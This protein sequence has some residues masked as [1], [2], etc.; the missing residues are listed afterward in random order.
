M[1]DSIL[2]K[3]D[4]LGEQHPEKLLYSYID[5]NGNP[6]GGYSYEEFLHRT[7]VI[8]AH[9]RKMHGF[10]S[11]QRLL[12]AYPPG[13]EMICAFFGCV[14]A[15]LIP[16]P[17][18]PP[19]SRDFRSALY[20]MVHIAQ[21]CQAA[22]ILTSKDYLGSLKTNLA[23]SEVCG[24]GV[25]VDYISSL[26]WVVTEDFVDAIPGEIPNGASNILFLQ[27]TSGSTRDPK[28]VM[29]THENILHNCPLVIDHDEP[30][31]V[32]W[33]PQ[34]HDM[35][36]IGCYLYPALKGGT[37][38]G[39]APTDFI[40]RPSLWFDAIKTYG[41]SAS[42]APNFAYDYCLRPGRVSRESLEACDLSSLR[43]LLVAAEPVKPDTY[44]RFL[45]AF[46]PR[47][48]RAESFFVAYGLAE[49]T[50]AVSLG[51]R[52]IISVNKNAIA[53]GK[54]RMTKEVSEIG[55][56]TQIVSCGTP[57]PGLTVKIVDPEKHVALEP[58]RIGEIW[59]A[60]GS[61][62]LGCWNNPELTMKLFHARLVDDSPYDD[63][64]L[65][66]GDMGF[67]HEGELFVCGRI[68]DMIILR[69]QNYYPQDI[70]SVVEKA[71]GLVRGNCVVAF[72]INEDTDPA[73]AIL[74]E[75]KNLKALPDPL[76]IAAAVR[77]FLN[78]EVAVISFIA[79]RAIPRT[80]S[81]KIMRQKTK[82][83]WLQGQFT[84]VSEFS[85]K[86][87]EGPTTSGAIVQSPFDALKA[88]YNLTGTESYNLVEA[89][90]DSLDLVVFMHE[91]KELLK[92][93]DADMLARQV[94]I[95]LIQRVSVAELFRL[96]EQLE[97]APEEA[98][99]PL[100][101]TLAAFREEQRAA[102]QQMMK[103]DA[104][105][106]FEPAAPRNLQ[107]TSVSTNV[108][109]RNVLLTGGTGFIG[110]FLVKSL[111]EQTRAS[112]HVLVRA[113]DERQGKQRLRAAMESMG[114]CPA[115]LAEMFDTRVIPVCGDLSHQDL[116]LTPE[117]WDSLA[118]KIDTVFH[119]G[120][121]VNYLLNYDR[122][123]DANVLGTNEI[124]RLAFEGRPK[125]FNYVSTTFIFGWAVKKVLYETD[126]NE[127]MELL[128]F[129][130][131]QSKWV[132]E[133]VVMDARRRGLT[134]RIFRPALVSPSITGG[135]N[136]FDIAVRLV[137]FMVNHGIGVD[138]LNQVSFVPAD[139]TANNIVAVSTTPGTENKT[140]H[141]VRDDYAN[142]LDITRLITKA[143]G[144]QF[145]IFS[146]S[147]FVPE[148]V[149]RCR[150]EDL[151]FPLLDFLVGSV[152][153]ISAMEF[154]RYDNSSY[155][156]ARGAST[157]GKPDPSLE[158]TV[159]GILKFMQRKGIISVGMREVSPVSNYHQRVSRADASGLAP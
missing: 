6:I 40:Q 25:N 96:A 59:I 109:P 95:S 27:Y 126:F 30:V 115:K 45:Q 87:E 153:N 36:L 89:G 63:G 51:G 104:R 88:R 82:H 128:D 159:N 50:L 121:T 101:Q 74:A 110:P 152:D 81:G 12:L 102:E 14:R 94:D 113:S 19:S 11:Q 144:R 100:R 4:S 127:K 158:D 138:A 93:R 119:N 65:R 58:G 103:G 75:V 147:E 48:L 35:G 29:V 54:A 154:K 141:V 16:V 91:I 105:L 150:K 37:T 70:E 134:T 151:L 13:L 79:P 49:N 73:L 61:K 60:G 67:I 84:V 111:L 140:Y 90:L 47:G 62:C 107:E 17:V 22:G 3:L 38:Y 132:S 72:Q 43:Q 143:T 44:T 92:N 131:S 56:A 117:V 18:Y 77:N 116:G 130:Y 120:A 122:M 52:N 112:V 146:L 20:K 123:R 85:R 26:R 129:G 23:R 135:G 86:R 78:V 21:D 124:V 114:P 108:L 15:G 55:S 46:Q 10:E 34:Y 24:S 133:Q 125:T 68:K 64:Y 8:A 148:L 142:M 76:K 156:A 139:I 137:A 2:D 145:E 39:F 155:Q 1:I 28:G 136:N 71:S 9:L 33:L 80:S 53:L 118:N 32:S 98:L 157:W 99:G 97:R 106:I 83:M 7:K 57:L 66:T 5:V 149:R 31:V 42:A 69:G 41:A